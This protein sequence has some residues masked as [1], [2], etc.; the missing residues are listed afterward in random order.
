MS[1]EITIKVRNLSKVYKL[2]NSPQ[3]RL[4]ESLHPMRKKYH[5]NYYALNDVS[6]DIKK[7]ETVGIIGKNGSGKSTLLKIITGVLTP[8]DGSVMVNGKISALL[9]LGAGFNPELTGVENVY[10]NGTLL[11]YTREEMVEKIDS[12]LSFADIG[13]FVYQPVKTYSSG[14]F[15][16][17][18]FAVAIKVDPDILIVDEALSVGDEAFQRKCFSCFQDFQK[19]GKTIIFVSHAA[20]TIVELCDR[21]M[22]FDQ[23][24]LLLKGAPKSVVA[25][26][27]KLVY[28]PLE[29]LAHLRNEFRALE[30]SVHEHIPEN[31]HKESW[32]ALSGEMVPKQAPY[33]PA[34]SFFDPNL[35][36]KSTL[37]YESRGAVITDPHITCL[38]GE[39]AN[40]LVRGEEY[41]FTY[42]VHFEEDAHKV[43]FGM[44]VKTVTGNELGGLV[45]HPWAKPI[46]FIPKGTGKKQ[47]FIFK[48]ALLPGAYFLNAGVLGSVSG[49]ETFLYRLIDAFMFR[50]QPEQYLL[51]TGVVDLSCSQSRGNSTN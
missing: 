9:E 29:K 38:S 31:H 34:T 15:I 46:D 7:G 33:L 45:S 27:Q 26:Y 1:D 32:N 2:Y 17:L 36:A 20:A 4:K 30:A 24:E 47:A 10:F 41:V 51:S 37:I 35:S 3:E 50:V 44:L 12:I 23:G 16:R 25:N 13:D 40:I 19:Q 49:T 42:M 14:M 22:L 21:A 39:K 18:A 6:F 43:R 28:A 11:G 48:C 8:T 5:K